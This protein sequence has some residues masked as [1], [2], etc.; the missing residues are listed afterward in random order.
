M[1][2]A[3]VAVKG[4]P[5]GGGITLKLRIATVELK[6]LPAKWWHKNNR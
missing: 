5:V 3:F 1:N 4:I 6:G 2:I